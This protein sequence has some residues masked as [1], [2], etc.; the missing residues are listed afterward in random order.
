MESFAVVSIHGR[1]GARYILRGGRPGLCHRS[2]RATAVYRSSPA[3]AR[4]DLDR[5]TRWPAELGGRRDL[6]FRFHSRA[7]QQITTNQGVMFGQLAFNLSMCVYTL[8]V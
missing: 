3:T 2:Q 8:Y 7:R 1:R 6:P 4:Q 5:A